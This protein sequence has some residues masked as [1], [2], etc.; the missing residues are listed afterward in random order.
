[1]EDYFGFFCGYSFCLIAYLNEVGPF[2][3]V[4]GHPPKSLMLRMMVESGL[5][6]VFLLYNFPCIY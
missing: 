3:L 2:E 5:Q 4:P 6:L 1:M